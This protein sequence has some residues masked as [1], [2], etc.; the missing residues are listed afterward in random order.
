MKRREFIAGLAGTVAWPVRARAQQA[1]RVRRIGVLSMSDE[2]DPEGQ[3]QL[4]LFARALQDLGWTQG[5][6]LRMDVRW[7]IYVDR[8]RVVAKELVGLQPD[9]IVSGATISTDAF[10]RETRTIPVV[11]VS[12]SDPV[13]SGFVESL[14]HP[15]GNITGFTF[16]EAGM[17]GKWLQLLAEIA[18]HVKRVAIMF[19]SDTTL[20]PFYLPAFNAAARSLSVEPIVAPVGNDADIEAVMTSL[21]RQPG[22]GL[23]VVTGPFTTAHRATIIS[24]AA[25]NNL[26]AVYGSSVTPRDGR[27]LSYGIDI[28]DLWLRTAPYVDRILRGEKPADL[29]VQ[30][31]VKFEMTVNLKT[32][33][34]LGLT[35]PQSIVLRADEVIE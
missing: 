27:L 31:P 1:E 8:S 24:L 15:G 7:A 28:R 20:R 4:A 18:P 13:G 30:M 34:A 22:G 14:A 9:V 19:N 16:I 17:T 33:K 6:N 26:P 10:Q 32:A 2:D 29:P 5:R 21:A 12:V 25:S 11:F 35:V 23:I 3:A